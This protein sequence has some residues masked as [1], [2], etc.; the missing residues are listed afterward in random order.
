[1]NQ[2]LIYVLVAPVTILIVVGFSSKFV[3]DLFYQGIVNIFNLAGRLLFTALQE[4]LVLLAQPKT[5]DFPGYFLGWLPAGWRLIV[6]AGRWVLELPHKI[7]QYFFGSQGA[8]SEPAY[9]RPEV[10]LGHSLRKALTSNSDA[11]PDLSLRCSGIN[12]TGKKKGARCEREETMTVE[13]MGS[14]AGAWYCRQH[15]NQTPGGNKGGVGIV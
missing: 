6:R 15:Q 8:T 13:R 5:M 1:M 11:N 12:A 2:L 7:D 4:L 14:V 10:S 9:D 3:V